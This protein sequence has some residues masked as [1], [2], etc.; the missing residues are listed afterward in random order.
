MRLQVPLLL[1]RPLELD[2]LL[3]DVPLTSLGGVPGAQS[4]R[5]NLHGVD[6]RSCRGP[7]RKILHIGK[8]ESA[9]G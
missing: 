3:F 8:H 7:E 6:R 5:K 9:G 1:G 4:V 2:V